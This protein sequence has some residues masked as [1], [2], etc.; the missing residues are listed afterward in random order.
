MTEQHYKFLFGHTANKILL[1][2]QELNLFMLGVLN[3]KFEDWFF[4]KTSTNNHVMGYELRQLP[5]PNADKK[6]IEETASIVKEIIL[7][8]RAGKDYKKQ[9]DKVNTIIYNLYGLSAQ[10]IKIIER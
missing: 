10:Q 1:K 6:T 4:R 2:D 8:A 5:I 7:L 3:S 9:S